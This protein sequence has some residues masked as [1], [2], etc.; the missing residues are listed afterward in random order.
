MKT[1]E[2]LRKEAEDLFFS[3]MQAPC[4]PLADLASRLLFRAGWSDAVK[5]LTKWRDTKKELPETDKEVLVT[6]DA[7]DHTHDVM[8]Y[9]QHGWWQ[10]APGGGWCAAELTPAGW[11]YI[12]EI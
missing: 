10:K 11:R 6:V 2:E 9:D 4:S 3:K 7:D 5:E 12:Q 8:K 1:L